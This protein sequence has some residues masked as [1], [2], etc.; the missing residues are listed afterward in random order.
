MVFLCP[1]A[2]MGME[3]VYVRRLAVKGSLIAVGKD[4]D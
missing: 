1:F 2:L 4:Q 3:V